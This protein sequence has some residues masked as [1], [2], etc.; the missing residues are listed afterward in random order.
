MRWCKK[1]LRCSWPNFCGEK[2]RGFG[3]TLFDLSDQQEGEVP[4]Y[5]PE[6]SCLLNTLSK[7]SVHGRLP[8][9]HRAGERREARLLW[10]G[11]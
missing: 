7:A 8:C 1:H 4:G 2:E 11:G 6:Q 5:T 9:E 10:S 3:V